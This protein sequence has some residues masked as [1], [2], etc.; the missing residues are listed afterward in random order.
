VKAVQTTKGSRAS[1]AKAEKR[2]WRT[3]V[4]PDL[5]EFLS[6]L[7]MFYLGTAS[8]EGQAYIQYKGGSP[9]FLKVL[10]GRTLGFADY[11]GNRQ[12]ITLGNLSENPERSSS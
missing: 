10:D 6:G 1:Y 2:G 4:T 8:A 9:G 7:D 5:T 3:L 12:Y 11:G